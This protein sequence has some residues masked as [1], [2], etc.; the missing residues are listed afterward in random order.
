MSYPAVGTKAPRF[1]AKD[2][3]GDVKKISDLVGSKGIVIYFY[4]KDSTPGCTTEACDFRDNLARIQKFGYTVVGISKDDTKSHQKFTEKQNLNFPL[5]SD[6]TGEIC[7][8]YGVWQ[9]KNFMGRVGMGIVRTSFLLDS[10]LKVLKLY[11]KVK[12]N[13]HVDQILQ[14]IQ[15]LG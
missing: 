10:N 8:K 14:D 13:G 15:N 7:E 6:E 9:E 12:V 1:S 5:L 2:T 4:P 3:N 11:E